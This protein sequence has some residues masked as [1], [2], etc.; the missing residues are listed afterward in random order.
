MAMHASLPDDSVS[1]FRRVSIAVAPEGPCPPGGDHH[2]L[3]VVVTGV[4][5]GNRATGPSIVVNLPAVYGAPG[6]EV[7]KRLLGKRPGMPLTVVT[8]LPLLGCVDAE[9]PHKLGAE[10]H[11]IAIYDLKTR[12]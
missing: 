9:Q 5:L 8:G 3:E 10:S 11:G 2:C 4:A 6:D 7:L 12:P 1:L